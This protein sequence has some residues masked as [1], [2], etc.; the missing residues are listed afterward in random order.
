LDNSGGKEFPPQEVRAGAAAGGRRKQWGK[1]FP[2]QGERGKGEGPFFKSVSWL[3]S[4][5]PILVLPTD[6]LEDPRNKE[7]MD[8]STEGI[9]SV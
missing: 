2:L 7:M 3:K 9:A 4:E 1:E 8:S 6:S 5:K